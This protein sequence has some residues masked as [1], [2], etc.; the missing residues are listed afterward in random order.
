MT[1][2]FPKPGSEGVSEGWSALVAGALD[3]DS[4][5]GPLGD[6]IRLFAGLGFAER[7]KDPAAAR[8]QCI[9]ISGTFAD[10]CNHRGIPAESVTG[11]LFA[12]IPPFEQELVVAGHTAVQVQAPPPGRDS[13]LVIDWTARQHDPGVPVPLVVT[14]VAWRAFW[15]DLDK[16]TDGRDD[17]PGHAP[18]PAALDRPV[19]PAAALPPTTRQAAGPGKRPGNPSRRSRGRQR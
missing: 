3:P 7:L 10:A 5:G 18:S 16:S 2:R 11:F 14:S 8:D 13:E 4:V 9:S 19:G 1:E 12:R 6:V 15:R 17:R